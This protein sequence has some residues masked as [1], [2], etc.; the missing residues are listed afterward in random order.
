MKL[1]K[2]VK[3]R[4]NSCVEHTHNRRSRSRCGS[5]VYTRGTWNYC[6][7]VHVEVVLV[8]LQYVVIRI[9]KIPGTTYYPVAAVLYT[10][11]S[12]SRRDQGRN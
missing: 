2:L 8:V 6:S 9:S 4:Q 7:G 10:C 3:V 1:V 5:G 12:V 11:V